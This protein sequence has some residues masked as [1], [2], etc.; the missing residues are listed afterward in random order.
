MIRKAIHTQTRPTGEHF[1]TGDKVFYKRADCPEWKGPAVVIGGESVVI[2]VRH[3]GTYVRVHKNRLR[4]VNSPITE[5]DQNRI[6]H[7]TEPDQDWTEPLS[8]EDYD[9]GDNDKGDNSGADDVAE[10]APEHLQDNR[11]TANGDVDGT[12]SEAVSDLKLRP[13]QTISFFS[14]DGEN[15]SC[16]RVIIQPCWPCVGEIQGLVFNIEYTHP[17]EKAGNMGSVDLSRVRDLQLQVVQSIPT[18]SSESEDIMMVD[19]THL[20]QA[21]QD[22][23]GH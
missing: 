16:G 1:Q 11:A 18:Q 8:D 3:G 4:K 22:V 2:F 15:Q 20:Q 6:E 12:K 10:Q 9:K 14:E 7:F 21:K 17:P 19:D 5:P 13:R 23:Q